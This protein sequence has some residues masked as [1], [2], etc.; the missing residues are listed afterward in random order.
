MTVTSAQVQQDRRKFPRNDVRPRFEINL[1]QPPR[2][3]AAGSV[4]FSEGGL[5]L[6]LREILEVRS[7]IRLQVTPEG[8]VGERTH[9]PVQCTGRV[10]WVIQRLDLSDAPPFLY[11]VGI[12]FIDPPQFLR[13][14]L[15]HHRVAAGV[16]QAARAARERSLAS[17]MVHGREFVPHLERTSAKP[18]PW[19]LIVMVDG[20]PCF[21]HHYAS[22]RLALAA[23]ASFRRQEAR[24]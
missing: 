5:C 17:A 6:R 10:R 7:L 24:R 3:I 2:T 9:R 8:G 18:L 16:E 19:H 21:S 1:V 13:Q 22:E 20:T 15:G 11:D 12:E 23:W 4:N 14:F